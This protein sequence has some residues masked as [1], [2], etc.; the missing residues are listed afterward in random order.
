[1]KKEVDTLLALKADYKKQTGED[2]KPGMSPPT[3]TTA[4]TNG[5]ANGDSSGLND[6]ITAQG[7]KVRTLK[8]EKADK[9]CI[10]QTVG[11]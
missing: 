11:G 5:A 4:A 10:I 7:N 6:K 3:A 9:V 8:S 2:Y 1:M